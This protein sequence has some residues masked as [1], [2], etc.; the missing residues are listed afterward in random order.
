M[1]L[2]SIYH[3]YSQRL[4]RAVALI[5]ALRR[6]VSQR[7]GPKEYTLNA[8]EDFRTENCFG[9]GQNLALTGLLVPNS[10]DSGVRQRRADSASVGLMAPM[11]GQWLQQL[12]HNLN[13]HDPVSAEYPASSYLMSSNDHQQFDPGEF[14][15]QNT[16]AL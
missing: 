1:D 5:G 2:P 3:K 8:F 13:A 12:L 11:P 16:P 9:Q 15:R 10:L 14:L 6:T 4:D 7:R